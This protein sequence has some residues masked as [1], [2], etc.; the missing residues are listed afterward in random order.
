MVQ[1]SY[2]GVY[3]REVPS[4]VNSISGVSTSV[5]AFVGM[6]K[7]GPMFTPTRVLGFRDYE[8]V[9]S[10]DTSLGEMTDQ[11]R[12]F[13]FNGGEEAL[14][15][16]VA[17]SALESTVAL[18]SAASAGILTLTARD[19]GLA[20]NELRVKVDYNTSSPERTFNLT[21][22]RETFDSSGLPV[23][24]QTETFTD[25]SMSAA[26][27]RYVET[28][29]NQ[30]SALVRAQVNVGAVM[31]AAT[32]TGYSATSRIFVDEPAAVAAF[33]NAVANAGPPGG[34]FGRFRIKVGPTPWL[35]VQI[36]STG[37]TLA[38]VRQAINDALS[39]HTTITV[40][41]TVA[42][43]QPLRV[44]ASVPGHDVLFDVA[45]QLDIAVAMGLGAAQGGLEVSSFSSSRPNPSGLVSQIEVVAGSLDSLLAF[46]AVTK[47]GLATPGL[48]T[49]RPFTVPASPGIAYPDSSGT[50]QEGTRATGLNSLLN[51]RENLEAIASALREASRDW[52]AQVHGYRLVITSSFGDTSAGAGAGFVS[53]SPNLG[54]GG[55][56]FD[57]VSGERRAVPMAGGSDGSMP[58]DADYQRAYQRIDESVDLFNLLA[59]PKSSE[60][61]ASPS[62]R[63]QQWGPASAFCSEKR[64][65]LI[66]D[67]EPLADTP[68]AVLAANQ[69]LRNGI[70]K[71]HTA[72]YW[73]RVTISSGGIRKNV[74]PSGSVA[75][76]MARIDGSRG[77]WK[78]PA[79]LD[80]D[81]RAVLGVQTPLSDRQNG[82]LNPQAV[83]VIRSFPA[84]IVCWGAR[85]MDGFE[86]SGNT[87]YRYIP[88]RRLA[89]YIEESLARGL[90]FAVFEPNDEPLW[91]QIRLAAGAFM[92]GL[93]RRGAFAGATST[94]A[95]FV[96]ADAETTTQTD[97]NLGIVNVRV[98]F[99]PLK[100]AE[101]VVIT[102]QQKAGQVQ[103]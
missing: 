72:V 83:N 20:S 95:Y 64:A 8:R 96:Q 50:I 18:D 6:C 89:L 11:V 22:F 74:D 31:A 69:S 17:D 54:T 43:N 80:T 10:S 94:E 47:A 63:S 84:G 82:I 25:L 102:I 58:G 24:G 60:D 5:T 28:V 26:G 15:V 100:P 40:A 88:P 7:S 41:V 12:Q 98:G 30:A 34:T 13:F 44:T 71:D 3:T 103:V 32:L 48:T 92:N 66:A 56:I 79:G 65:F 51:L 39:P 81:L 62:V 91:A 93:F 90:R 78:A 73:P 14:I 35:T 70:V 76:A 49:V 85:T 52:T 1:V 36:D 53:A 45:G 9:F 21:V 75:G 55:H 37:L 19:A 2:P 23:V 68:E 59:L 27:G 46:A 77:V 97:R 99:A 57:G 33:V 67:L 87:D 29:V 61:T 86:N 42:A 101:F 16:R 4:G 38:S